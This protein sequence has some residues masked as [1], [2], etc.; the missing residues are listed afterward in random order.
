LYLWPY[1]DHRFP[2]G[3]VQAMLNHIRLK[4][5]GTPG[6]LRE[7]A[8]VVLGCAVEVDGYMPSLYKILYKQGRWLHVQKK[9]LSFLFLNQVFFDAK[10]LPSPILIILRIYYYINTES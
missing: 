7:G 3:Q 4:F 1:A 8:K 10:L 5:G 9:N 2:V 6:I